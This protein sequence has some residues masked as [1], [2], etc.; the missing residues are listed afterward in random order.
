MSEQLHGYY[1]EK[2]A[3]DA[4][5]GGYFI[6]LTPT[7]EKVNVT[8]VCEEKDPSSYL[9][10]DKIY[11]GIVTKQVKSNPKLKIHEFF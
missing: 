4:Q 3:T 11:V 1:S 7:G 9:W 6:Y 8:C 5:I 2:H 10:D